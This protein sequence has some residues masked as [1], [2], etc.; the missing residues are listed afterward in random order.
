MTITELRTKLIAE[1]WWVYASNG[2]GEGRRYYV[3]DDRYKRQGLW[4]ADRESFRQWAIY[5]LSMA[6]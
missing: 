4:R 5:Q 6:I 2:H 3:Q 1:G